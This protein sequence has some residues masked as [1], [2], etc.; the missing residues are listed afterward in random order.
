MVAPVQALRA[1]WIAQ[2]SALILQPTSLCNLDCSYC[3]LPDRLRKR[4]MSVA[5][6][7][8]IVA[9]IA[10]G[11]S[12]RKP[13][14]IV[15]HGGEPLTIGTRAL[16]EIMA[17]FEPLR[18]TGRV[19]YLVQTNATLITDE[20]CDLFLGYDFAVGVSIDGPAAL[21]GERVDRGGRPAFTRIMAGI[22][23]LQRR[24]I[25]F[26]VLA[27]VT[28][29]NAGHASTVLDFVAD[30]GVQQVGFNVESKEAAHR[31]GDVPSSELAGQF[32]AETFRWAKDHPEVRIR[33]VDRLTEYLAMDPPTRRLDAQHDP[34]PTIGWNGDVGLFSPE[35][36]GVHD[37]THH[38]FV[39][40]N[41]LTEPLS[42][43]VANA[44][45]LRYVRDFAVGIQRCKQTCEFFAY[46]QG[47][48]PGI[49]TSNMATSA[50][51]K[52]NIAEPR[53]KRPCTPCTS[54]PPKD[55]HH[56]H[57]R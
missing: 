27:V 36:L 14:E 50:P 46:C 57:A 23:V 35:L 48:H 16:R 44:S 41:V 47:V 34:L 30:L 20:W 13:L 12:T 2:P 21:N 19:R 3:Y 5:V 42:A 55:G 31:D 4:D 25:P 51:P 39:A 8:A 24:D 10:A 56:E 7:E 32:W 45:Q 22:D 53:S 54:S 49:A 18:E 9:G 1:D 17:P 33:E 43:I 52:P 11:W 29:G 37:A 40:G 38:D 15:W 28:P 26:T 6:A